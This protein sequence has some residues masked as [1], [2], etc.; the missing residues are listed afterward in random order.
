M[1]SLEQDLYGVVL[2]RDY[3]NRIVDVEHTSR[4]AREKLWSF[5]KNERVRREARRLIRI[6]TR[7]AHQK[8]LS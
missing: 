7:E 4:L 3:P 1:S 5:K 6:H 2:G 8:S